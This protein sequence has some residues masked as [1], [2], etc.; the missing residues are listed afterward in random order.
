M[1][2]GFP[3]LGVKN[4]AAAGSGR[5]VAIERKFTTLLNLMGLISH[6]RWM[7][8]RVLL[9]HSQKN[10]R[11]SVSLRSQRRRLRIA[12]QDRAGGIHLLMSR[13]ADV[14]RMRHYFQVFR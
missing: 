3:S 10:F 4:A 12:R 7:C 2:M 8:V 11:T 1:L 5:S 13:I 14:V 6:L 9:T